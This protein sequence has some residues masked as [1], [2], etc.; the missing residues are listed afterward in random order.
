[1][2]TNDTETSPLLPR[3]VEHSRPPSSVTPVP[4]KQILTLCAV[5]VVDPMS[6]AQ[7]LPYINDMLREMKVADPSRVGFYSG[8]IES[9]FS[10]AVI[11][12]IYPWARLSGAS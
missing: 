1:M 2:S 3:D 7:I 9:S 6:F 4:W 10:V 12:S 11:I 8:I 5:R